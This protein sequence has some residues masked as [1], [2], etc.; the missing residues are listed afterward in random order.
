MSLTP[1]SFLLSAGFALIAGASAVAAVAGPGIGLSRTDA[2]SAVVQVSS[3]DKADADRR[4]TR[5]VRVDAPYAH[6]EAGRRVRV[7]APFADV[8]VNTD[9]RRVRVQAPFADVDVRW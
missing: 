9:R 8:D 3:G 7:D 4:R 5:D 6:V 2:S 1:R